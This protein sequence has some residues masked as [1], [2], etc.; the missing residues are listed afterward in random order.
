MSPEPLPAVHNAVDHYRVDEVL[1]STFA[2]RSSKWLEDG[3]IDQVKEITDAP[4][5]HI[6]SSGGT[7][8]PVAAGAGA[9]G[10]VS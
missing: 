2:G 6:E 4:I 8:E 1:I 5:E 3:L 7:V 9:A 10:A